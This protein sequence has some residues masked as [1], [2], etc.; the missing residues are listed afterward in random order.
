M[1][2]KQTS[3]R[4]KKTNPQPLQ[5]GENSLFI[6][7]EVNIP[8]FHLNVAALPA[9]TS[10]RSVDKYEKCINSQPTEILLNTSVDNFFTVHDVGLSSLPWVQN[11]LNLSQQCK[12]LNT[13]NMVPDA[14]EPIHFVSSIFGVLPIAKNHQL[15]ASADFTELATGLHQ[16]NCNDFEFLP[17]LKSSVLPSTSIAPTSSIISTSQIY[18]NYYCG[19]ENGTAGYDIWFKFTGSGWTA[20]LQKAFIDAGKYF[21]NLISAD[22][23][24][25]TYIKGIKVDDLYVT[26]D[27]KSIDGV[28]GILGQAGPTAVWS[29]T[30]LT[31]IGNMQFDSAD[32]VNYSKLGLWDDI[33]THEL[34]H[35]LGFG[36]LWNYGVNPLVV[37]D[38]YTGSQGVAAYQSSYGGNPSATF[39][40]VESSGGS[41][42]A[43]SHWSETVLQNEL[44][45]GYINSNN[46]LSKFSL[47]TL[48][49]LGYPIKYNDYIY[50]SVVI[51]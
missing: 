13:S 19:S 9:D 22:I 17:H 23:G 50:D 40:P 42:T 36:S 15:Y 1:S 10:T 2:L 12:N 39:I 7:S 33:V 24:G 28:G 43:G 14:I 5:S 21:T 47:M 3:N 32:A 6:P 46:Y 51:V 45:T 29:T 4:S 18:T 34:M 49:D 16:L 35:V 44:M 8:Y 38:K 27:L 48:K 25:D 20:T 30:E 31:A 26:V 11:S 41:G 37:G